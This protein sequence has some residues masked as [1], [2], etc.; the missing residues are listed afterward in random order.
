MNVMD[1]MLK[2]ELAELSGELPSYLF[3]LFIEFSVTKEQGKE[4]CTC[5]MRCSNL[6]T[7]DSENN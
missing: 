3:F 6:V 5:R 7:S 2:S 1:R 4:L